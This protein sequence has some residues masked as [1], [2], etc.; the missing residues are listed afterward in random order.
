MIVYKICIVGL[1][2]IHS[3]IVDFGNTIIMYSVIV[4]VFTNPSHLVIPYN[5]MYY[6]GHDMYVALG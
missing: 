5:T 6:V 3:Y 1:E 2:S 4:S